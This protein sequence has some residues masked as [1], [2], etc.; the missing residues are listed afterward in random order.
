LGCI[1]PQLIHKPPAGLQMT[2]AEFR[3]EIQLFVKIY[4]WRFA[5]G[6]PTAAYYCGLLFAIIHQSATSSA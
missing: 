4:I 5:H 2:A 3:H 6:Y 1:P